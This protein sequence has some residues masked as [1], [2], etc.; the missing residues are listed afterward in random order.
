MLL[1][2]YCFNATCSNQALPRLASLFLLPPRNWY[3]TFLR[4]IRIR[5]LPEGKGGREGGGE[6][7]P[8][9]RL[10][11][12]TKGLLQCAASNVATRLHSVWAHSH[13]V[14]IKTSMRLIKRNAVREAFYCH[15]TLNAINIR[16]NFCRAAQVSLWWN[17]MCC[18]VIANI[19]FVLR[20]IQF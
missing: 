8:K 3:A 4:T 12:E 2:L 20:A 1:W 9:G 5:L 6:V 15:A 19:S 16:L 7:G 17:Y 13:D 10:K 18:A 11:T 14:S